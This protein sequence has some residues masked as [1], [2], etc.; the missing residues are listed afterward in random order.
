MITAND[1]IEYNKTGIGLD[2]TPPT[3]PIVV[4]D[5]AYTNNNTFLHIIV[6]N[7]SDPE[8]NELGLNLDYRYRL[9]TDSS[10]GSWLTIYLSSSSETGNMIATSSLM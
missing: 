9:R 2:T 3:P 10:N 5:G 7:S 6:L 1:T 4:D 8:A